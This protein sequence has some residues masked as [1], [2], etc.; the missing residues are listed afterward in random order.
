MFVV[1][2][3][4]RPSRDTLGGIWSGNVNMRFGLTPGT[5]NPW[6]IVDMRRKRFW[7]RKPSR[8]V[9]DVLQFSDSGLRSSRD[10]TRNTENK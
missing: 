5:I 2:S 7:F 4:S 1:A 3:Y 8:G 10:S 6:F 9:I